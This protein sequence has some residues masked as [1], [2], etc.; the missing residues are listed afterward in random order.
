MWNKTLAILSNWWKYNNNNNNISREL[1][2]KEEENYDKVME[3]YTNYLTVFYN[4][5]LV[6]KQWLKKRFI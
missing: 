3:S 6:Y 2:C 1:E 5:A 4:L